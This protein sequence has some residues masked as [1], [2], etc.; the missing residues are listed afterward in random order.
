MHLK[1]VYNIDIN[2]D[3]NKLL[4]NFLNKDNQYTIPIFIPHKGCPNNC[5]FCNQKRISG[6]EDTKE[7]EV[8]NIIETHLQYFKDS[9]KNIEIAFFGGSFTG[10]DINLQNMYL[11]AAYEYIKY[12]RVKSIRLSTRPD[13]INDTILKN[14]KKYGVKNIE[15][16]VQSMDD[17]I[18]EYSKRGHTREDVIKASNLIKLYGFNLGHQVMVGL[19]GS[20]LKTEIDTIKSL[21]KLNPNDLR[22]YP[23]YVLQDSELYD[24]YENKEYIPLT[25]DEAIER[26]YYILKEC[27]KTDVKIIRLGLQ[28]T[29][30]ITA[31]NKNIAGPVCDNFAEYVMARIIKEYIEENLINEINKNVIKLDES[32]IHL[33]IHANNYYS[34]VIYGPKKVNKEYFY[35]KY[36]CVMKIR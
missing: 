16:G 32:I 5:I 18:L 2:L 4:K 24:M 23:V 9:N 11:K 1:T 28:S 15:L 3:V 29:N 17:N 26:V 22:I 21:L 36:N 10:I 19:P 34:S 27:I 33:N 7:E 25:I 14:L 30:E 8:K 31:S 6:V 20:T 13:Y 35:N 12:G